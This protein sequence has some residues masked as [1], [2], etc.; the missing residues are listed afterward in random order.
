MKVSLEKTNVM[1]SGG[2]I[3]DSFYKSKVYPCA[4]CRLKVKATSNLCVQ[5]GNWIHG[6]HA[7][8]IKVNS[9]FQRNSAC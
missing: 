5:C 4:V 6:R 9:M 1:V 3:K 7:G 2:I 8:V